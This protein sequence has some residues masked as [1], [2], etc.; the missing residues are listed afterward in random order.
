VPNG[1][2]VSVTDLEK[3]TKRE[4]IEDI[5][6][7]SLIARVNVS[8]LDETSDIESNEEIDLEKNL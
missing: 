2:I 4:T 5:G 3:T 7:V 1:E 8:S 6:G